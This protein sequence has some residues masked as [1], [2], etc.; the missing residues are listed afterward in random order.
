MPGAAGAT[1]AGTGPL[2]TGPEIP[3]RPNVS[4]LG[5]LLQIVLAVAATAAPM[6]LIVRLIAGRDADPTADAFR[7][8]TDLAWPVGVQEED[9]RPWATAPA[10]GD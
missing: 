10:L 3:R 4:D 9:P 6:V 8:P 5:V 2:E 7:S 1:M